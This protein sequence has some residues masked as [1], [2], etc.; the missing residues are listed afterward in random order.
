MGGN[1]ARTRIK[2]NLFQIAGGE[3]QEAKLLGAR[4]RKCKNN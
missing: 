1:V 2:I 3:P 4:R